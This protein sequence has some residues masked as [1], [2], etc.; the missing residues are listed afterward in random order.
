[1]SVLRGLIADSGDAED[2]VYRAAL[3][4]LGFPADA[5]VDLRREIDAACGRDRLVEEE[6]LEDVAERVRHATTTAERLLP[7]QAGVVEL[8]L[9]RFLGFLRLRLLNADDQY[10][11]LADAVGGAEYIFRCACVLTCTSP[12]VRRELGQWIVDFTRRDVA[13][14]PVMVVIDYRES[15][16]DAVDEVTEQFHYEAEQ[17]SFG[18]WGFSSDDEGTRQLTGWDERASARDRAARLRSEVD[19]CRRNTKADQ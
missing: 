16:G 1:M 6:E 15:L 10:G 4:G 8:E 2:A 17:S 13:T 7:E 18:E 19:Q 14:E 9:R 3:E 5:V 11:H 12:E